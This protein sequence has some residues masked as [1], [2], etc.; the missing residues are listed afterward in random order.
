LLKQ[1]LR[2]SSQSLLAAWLVQELQI[3]TNPATVAQILVWLRG[4]R[5]F[6]FLVWLWPFGLTMQPF[7]SAWLLKSKG[8]IP[9]ILKLHLLLMGLKGANRVLGAPTQLCNIVPEHS[10]LNPGLRFCPK[11]SRKHQAAINA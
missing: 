1:Q 7:V 5:I 3:P 8:S 2:D 11:E 10:K 4:T 6:S 9:Q